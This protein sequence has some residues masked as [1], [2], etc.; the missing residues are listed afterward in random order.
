MVGLT[1]QIITLSSLKR[2]V[3]EVIHQKNYSLV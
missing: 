3:E 1:F 2:K